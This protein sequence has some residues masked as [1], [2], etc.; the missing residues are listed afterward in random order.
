MFLD[1]LDKL[2]LAYDIEPEDDRIIKQDYLGLDIEYK[3]GR[4]IIGNP[5]FGSR[6]NL[7]RQF[8]NKSIKIADY[9]A[10]ILPIKQL[11]N[12]YTLYKFDLVHSEDLGLHV[13]T[14]REIHC[15]FNIYKRPKSGL[16]K[17]PQTKL[18]D[19]DIVSS[20]PRQKI[21]FKDI[22]AD[23]EIVGWGTVGKI[24]KEGE[25]YT[26]TYKIIIKNKKLKDE[27]MYCLKKIDWYK[28]VNFITTP[29]INK[30]HIV[31]VLKKY[32]PD[33]K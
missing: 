3:K 17:R 5:P 8:Y 31:K 1:Y 28:E 11:D 16:N 4:C 27:I 25:R 18:K 23:L 15:C 29:R 21:N 26:D 32:I 12:N 7:A 20:D 19:V 9:I 2:Y 14:D 24:V 22:K 30:Y 33:I 10:F 13:Y 6:M